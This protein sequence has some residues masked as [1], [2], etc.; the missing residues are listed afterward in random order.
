MAGSWERRGKRMQ[1]NEI[2]IEIMD[3]AGPARAGVQSQLLGI[4]SLGLVS[5]TLA[6]NIK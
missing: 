6:Q 4:L 5:K 1:E 3:L 2:I